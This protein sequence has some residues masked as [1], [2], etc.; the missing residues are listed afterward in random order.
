MPALDAPDELTG[1]LL[2][3]SGAE[4]PP[5]RARPD[6]IAYVLFTSGSTGVP[7]GVPLTHRNLAAFVAHVRGR[8]PAAPGSRL[9]QVADLTF[10]PSV[11]DMF[12]AWSS[13]AAL[14][15]PS[16]EELLAPVEL[17]NRRRLTHWFSV[18]SLI[19]AAARAGDLR[20]GCM[21]TL[22]WSLFSGEPLLSDQA[23]FWQAA[24]PG[25]TVDNIYGPTELTGCFEYRLGPD[26]ARWVRTA[27][28]T[29]P[30]G[31]PYP[32]MEQLV[33]GEDGRPAP[34]GELVMRGVQRFPGYLDPAQNTGRFLTVD[35]AGARA[36]PG[37]EP[38]PADLWYRTGDVVTEAGGVLVHLGRLDS[39]VKV[40]GYR[41]EVGEVEAAIRDR[42]EVRDAVV[43]ARVVDDG[44]TELRAA[45]TGVQ[46]ETG[47]V[48]T[49]LGRLLPPYMVPRSLLVLDELPLNANGKIDRALLE[50]VLFSD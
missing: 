7:K 13:G 38:L 16:R 9:S 21:P 29:V 37:T 32:G 48:L 12:V 39:Q 31:S 44:E 1:E 19:S 20:P 30:I 50:E 2:T 6:D 43:V 26:P 25:S 18:P 34:L 33:L 14:V 46:V 4:P 41:V 40:R 11:H 10:D 22:R 27:N 8:Y 47:S 24:A 5:S 35:R 42:R 23:A 15:V 3:G 36:H 49:A 45:V 17:V 28:G